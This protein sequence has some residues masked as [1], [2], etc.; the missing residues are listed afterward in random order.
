MKKI[1][2]GLGFD[3]TIK[4]IIFF[5]LQSSNYET[6]YLVDELCGCLFDKRNVLHTKEV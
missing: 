2:S 4:Q 6:F 5:F 1:W 3:P